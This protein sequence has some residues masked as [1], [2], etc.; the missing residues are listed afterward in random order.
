MDP[1]QIN[2]WAVLVA[3][4]AS[5][6]IGGLWYSPLLFGHAWMAAIGKTK[7]Q[8]EKEFTP[9]Q[10]LVAFVVNLIVATVLSIIIDWA[11]AR[12]LTGGALIGGGLALGVMTALTGVDYFFE[13]RPAKLFL[14]TTAHTVVSLTIIGLIVGAWP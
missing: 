2:L 10:I 14:I 4:V 8:V 9:L 3:G 12:T 6:V 13:H 1:F 11:N 7:E 5:V